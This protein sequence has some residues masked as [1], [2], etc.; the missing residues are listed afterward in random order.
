M[1]VVSMEE[2][3]TAQQ[4]T[5]FHVTKV[6]DPTYLQT[7]AEETSSR[8]VLST[9]YQQ[10]RG[11]L[12]LRYLLT[13]TTSDTPLAE[14][15]I[16]SSTE[17]E[18]IQATLTQIVSVIETKL[19][20]LIQ[21]IEQ[22]GSLTFDPRSQIMRAG[23]VVMAL[24]QVEGL[25]TIT[26]VIRSWVQTLEYD[27]ATADEVREAK[28]AIDFQGTDITDPER[29]M[30]LG[31]ALFATYM[32]SG[33]LQ[34]RRGTYQLDIEIL[35]LG[36]GAVISQISLQG[37]TLDDLLDQLEDYL[38]VQ[39][40]QTLPKPQTMP[41]TTSPSPEPEQSPQDDST[42]EG[43]LLDEIQFGELHDDASPSETNRKTQTESVE[44]SS[45]SS[46]TSEQTSTTSF[47]GLR[48]R[49][50]AAFRFMAMRQFTF[51]TGYTVTPVDSAFEQTGLF[52]PLLGVGAGFEMGVLS[53]LNHR[54]ILLAL[55]DV[56]FETSKQALPMIDDRSG[57]EYGGVHYYMGFEE[58]VGVGLAFQFAIR[59]LKSEVGARLLYGFSQTVLEFIT[60]DGTETQTVM[61]HLARLGL[62]FQVIPFQ[63]K[64]FAI[65]LRLELHGQLGK[66]GQLSHNSF[67]F[68]FKSGLAF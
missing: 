19:A 66:N 18:L 13:D 4:S 17:E 47:E 36:E 52:A 25:E 5:G 22:T 2:T 58:N 57:V 56:N 32:F 51:D 3:K 38:L 67:G 62:Y 54:L 39:V 24:G 44:S 37:S 1:V 26:D 59:S 53:F 34:K 29:V 60:L 31:D 42:G 65:P 35:H 48:F 46:S 64:R 6:F 27:I 49:I 45:E 15:S 30:D 11:T 41:V 7:L 43:N 55:A 50:L 16:R 9:I 23:V 10:T 68:Y 8:W 12:R 33:L 28:D 14:D 61:G 21:P 40:Q 20:P 63:I